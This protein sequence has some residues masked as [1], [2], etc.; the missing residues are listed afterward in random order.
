[1]LQESGAVRFL[2]N[3]QIYRRCKW[4]C[5]EDVSENVFEGQSRDV[6][7]FVIENVSLD[8]SEDIGEDVG[9]E[10]SDK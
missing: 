2:G 4:G 1:M 6:S 3:Q 5:S 10:G 8:G 7:E 9:E